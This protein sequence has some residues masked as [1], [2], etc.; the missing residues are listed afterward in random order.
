MGCYFQQL[1]LSYFATRFW[2][3]WNI[4]SLPPLST[5]F[6]SP[7]KCAFILLLPFHFLL[8]M[9]L[10]RSWKSICT[11]ISQTLIIKTNFPSFPFLVA[12]N[13]KINQKQSC[14]VKLNLKKLSFLFIGHLMLSVSYFQCKYNN[15]LEHKEAICLNM[16]NVDTESIFYL[17]NIYKVCFKIIHPTAFSECLELFGIRQFSKAEYIIVSGIYT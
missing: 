11:A 10:P 14:F 13:L 9:Y 2:I 8:P 17:P 5:V 3:M 16:A 4:F 7:L 1:K 15:F 12:G 6:L